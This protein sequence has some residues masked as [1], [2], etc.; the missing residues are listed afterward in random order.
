[1]TSRYL[2]ESRTG[3]CG[4]P[5]EVWMIDDVEATIHFE[6]QHAHVRATS[7]NWDRTMG[8]HISRR[9]FGPS[10]IARKDAIEWIESLSYENRA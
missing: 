6:D 9:Y 1:M 8:T 3:A 4:C 2:V 7:D 5:E 10:D